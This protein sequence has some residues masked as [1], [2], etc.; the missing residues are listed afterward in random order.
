MGP[1]HYQVI[2]LLALAQI[3]LDRIM[4]GWVFD[5]GQS[6]WLWWNLFRLKYCLYLFL[7]GN[8]PSVYFWPHFLSE[9]KSLGVEIVRFEQLTRREIVSSKT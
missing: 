3:V 2:L 5:F 6:L 7:E 1:R 8:F 9:R 4:G